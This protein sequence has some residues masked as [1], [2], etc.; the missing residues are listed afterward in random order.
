MPHP[1]SNHIRIPIADALDRL[2][3]K[4]GRIL[5]WAYLLLIAT[6]IIQVVLRKGFANGFVALE[7][8]QWHLY[9]IGVMFG[10][11]YVQSIDAHV[12]VDLIKARISKKAQHL[13]EIIGLSLLVLPFIC[14]VFYHSLEFVETAWRI[15]EHSSAPAGLP[16]RWLIKSVIPVSFAFWLL[17]VVSRIIREISLLIKATQCRT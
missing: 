5:C 12:R 16:Y 2:I 6:I 11:S 17:S 8:L 3:I 13:I 14:I 10:I 9:A 4:S 15:G 7:E 1:S